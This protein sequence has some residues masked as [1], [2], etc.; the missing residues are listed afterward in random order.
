[1]KIEPLLIP[2]AEGPRLLNIDGKTLR[3]SHD[4]KHG[5]VPLHLA[6]VWAS[7]QGL[8]QLVKILRH[9]C[10][11]HDSSPCESDKGL[12]CAGANIMPVS[13]NFPIQFFGSL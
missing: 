2:D 10:V 1:V 8:G 5:L 11:R 13:I 3:R 9:T 6:S 4:R 12:S 7:E